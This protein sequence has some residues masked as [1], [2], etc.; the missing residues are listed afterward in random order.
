[1]ISPV[2]YNKRVRLA[3]VCPI[4]SQQKGYPFEV[5]LPD[6]LLARGLV[7]SDQIKSVDWLA[8]KVEFI[9]KVPADTTALVLKK[10]A[11]L[12]QG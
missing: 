9:C 8:R 7:L 4:T 5:S 6:G 12:T 11:R 3:L 2:S 1:M 10:L